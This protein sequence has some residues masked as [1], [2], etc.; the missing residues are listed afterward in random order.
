MDVEASPMLEL[1]RMA[2]PRIDSPI[3]VP[4]SPATPEA[5]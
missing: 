4:A 5:L 2:M 3:L 1:T